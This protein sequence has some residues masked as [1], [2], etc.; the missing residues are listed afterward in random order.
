MISVVLMVVLSL[1]DQIFGKFSPHTDA[2]SSALDTLGAPT[3]METPILVNKP[4]LIVDFPSVRPETLVGL[5][6]NQ[7]PIE[8]SYVSDSS[9]LKV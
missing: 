7:G 2:A 9:F 6:F 8:V 5:V 3:Y 1:L 4:S